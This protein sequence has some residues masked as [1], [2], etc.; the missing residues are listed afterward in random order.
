MLSGGRDHTRASGAVD[1]ALLDRLATTT[2]RVVVIPAASGRRAGA[3]AELRALRHWSRL[4]ATVELVT[5]G[6]TATP[7]AAPVALREADLLVLTGGRH[8]VPTAPADATTLWPHIVERWRQG[9]AL[10]GS[11]VGATMLC[12]WRQQIAAGHPLRFV[13]GHGVVPG[14]AVAPHFNRP[15]VRRWVLAASRAQPYLT[16]VGLDERT[17]IIGGEGRYAVHGSGAATVI[18]AGASRPRHAGSPLNLAADAPTPTIRF[19]HPWAPVDVLRPA[20]AR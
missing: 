1:R 7:A 14:V 12:E 18:R 15:V 5:A 20:A 4:G 10:S 17:A 2:P 9:A 8:A 16:I 3:A 11:A 19:P 6:G 13:H